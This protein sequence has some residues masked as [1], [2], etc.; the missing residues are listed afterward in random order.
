MGEPQEHH[1]LLRV[2]GLFV[3]FGSMAVLYTHSEITL[4]VQQE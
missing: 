3:V 4:V 2:V 1:S